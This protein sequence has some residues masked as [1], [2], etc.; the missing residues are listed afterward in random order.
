MGLAAGGERP[1][2]AERAPRRRQERPRRVRGLAPGAH[3]RP[4][5]RGRRDRRGALARRPARR[6]GDPEDVNRALRRLRGHGRPPVRV[7]R[8]ARLEPDGRG[9]ERDPGPRLRPDLHEGARPRAHLGGPLP[10]RG[11][12]CRTRD[13]DVARGA[14]AP[15]RTLAA[16]GAVDRTPFTTAYG[17]TRASPLRS[18]RTL[19]SIPAAAMASG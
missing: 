12:G 14:A 19:V 7:A 18:E 13:G 6:R 8:R 10:R 11:G 9:R 15:T 1:Q 4:A 3:R 2:A 5:P 17:L 16:T